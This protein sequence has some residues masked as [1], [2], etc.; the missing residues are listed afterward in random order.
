MFQIFVTS[1]IS[2]LFKTTFSEGSNVTLTAKFRNSELGNHERKHAFGPNS[3]AWRCG[4]Q[5][6]LCEV[7]RCK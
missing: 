5:L 3:V 1:N 4:R 6:R 2:D 7:S